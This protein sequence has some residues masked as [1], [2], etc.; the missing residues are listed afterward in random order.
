MPDHHLPTVVAKTLEMTSEQ[1]WAMILRK[2]PRFAED[3]FPM[4]PGLLKKFHDLV[5][6]LAYGEGCGKAKREEDGRLGAAD[7]PLIDLLR[8]MK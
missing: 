3:R 6:T 8:G 4:T 1:S 2:N 7:N 5:W